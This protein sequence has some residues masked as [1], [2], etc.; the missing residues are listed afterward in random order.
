MNEKKNE[1]LQKINVCIFSLYYSDSNIMIITSCFGDNCYREITL[2]KFLI[3]YHP[4]YNKYKNYNFCN[5][6]ML[7]LF[8]A[9]KTTRNYYTNYCEVC[10]KCFCSHSTNN[11]HDLKIIEKEFPVIKD[12]IF[13]VC[14]LEHKIYNNN[15]NIKGF[16]LKKNYINTISTSLLKIKKKFEEFEKDLNNCEGKFYLKLYPYFNLFMSRNYL[17]ILLCENLL[18]TYFSLREKKEINL[19]SIKNIVNLFIFDEINLNLGLIKESLI[20]S[21]INHFNNIT[22]C[23]LRKNNTIDIKQQNLIIFPF[24]LINKR[25]STLKK[26]KKLDLR[27]YIIPEIKKSINLDDEGNIYID[28]FNNEKSIYVGKLNEI[29]QNILY[30]QNNLF[31]FQYLNNFIVYSFYE[32]NEY[33]ELKEKS[34]ILI[35]KENKIYTKIISTH[36]KKFIC[37][38][39]NIVD[40]YSFNSLEKNTN[41]IKSLNDIRFIK[42]INENII[43]FSKNSIS[44]NSIIF[45]NKKGEE[46]N[47]INTENNF[48]LYEEQVC[49]YKKNYLLIIFSN[50]KNILLINI[51]N[52]E[53]IKNINFFT[54]YVYSQELDD[55][56]NIIN[57]KDEHSKIYLSISKKY[58][59]PKD[60]HLTYFFD[61]PI[62]VEN[63][64]G[65]IIF[66][67]KHFYFLYNIENVNSIMYEI[68][69]KLLDQYE[70]SLNHSN[71]KNNIRNIIKKY[72]NDYI[73]VD[74]SLS[75][76]NV[77]ILYSFSFD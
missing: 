20:N 14:P 21:L 5:K 57:E 55:D 6:C 23:F 44:N 74:Y 53:I 60:H 50:S 72:N 26:I 61:Y 2:N 7:K 49:I 62:V 8:Y 42:Q 36:N 43:I 34:K 37:L 9:Q 38:S 31:F 69:T 46:I 10:D 30:I 15:K 54:N 58:S 39:N 45:L 68:E 12:F 28:D 29:P 11:K 73:A 76:K 75:A 51:T 33:V 18:K 25:K 71:V 63:E 16:K 19:I 67:N 70:I 4:L 65:I 40:F 59:L 27:S 66:Y 22:N 1:N 48:C 64:D 3:E 17:E 52:F 35:N 24:K 41:Y 13:P 77:K 32:N 47:K 56:N